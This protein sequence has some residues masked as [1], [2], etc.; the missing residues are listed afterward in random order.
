M[1]RSN[2]A[3]VQV[4]ADTVPEVV[5][6]AVRPS[7]VRVRAADGTVLFE[8]ILDAGE[9]WILPKTE[10]PPL[11]RAGNAGSV[12]FAVNGETYGPAGAG[13]SVV[14]NVALGPEDLKASYSVADLTKDRDLAKIV[15]EIGTV[16]A[17]PNNRVA[18]LPVR[19]GRR[20]R[21]CQPVADRRSRAMS[22]NP[23]RPWRN[24]YRRKSR[25]IMVGNVPVGG[26]APITVQTM[27]NTDTTDVQGDRRA[28]AGRG[29]A[30]A[31]IVRV[32]TPDEASDAGRCARSSR[33]SPVPIVADIHFHYKRAI[34]AA[35]AGAACLRINPGNIGD[36][37]RVRE[38]IKAAR[39]HGCS[40]RIGVNAG[41]PGKASAGEIRRAVPRGDGRKRSR[42]HQDPA[43]QRFSRIQDQLQGVRRVPGRRRLSAAGRRHRRADPSGHHRGGRR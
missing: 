5:M 19:S 10:E 22:L 36:A 15:A 6:F 8:K 3:M 34:E 12:Y 4:V 11:L 29:E 7:W 24:I 26:D 30:G 21:N 39:D 17:P 33:E 20:Y 18:T 2:E 43:G 35:E 41:S 14:K 28:G 9:Q 1:P 13:P 25:Q 40:I 37:E 31:D 32:S 23:I 16:A 27:T 38:V 42:P